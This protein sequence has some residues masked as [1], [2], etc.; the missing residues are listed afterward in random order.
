MAEKILQTR[1][2]QKV[3]TLENWS[4][5]T[6]KIKKGE[7]CF[8]TV[9]AS[10]GTGLEEPVV[11]VKIGT[12]EEKTFSELP[13]AFHAKAA[14]VLAAC[15]TEAGLTAFVN[16]VIANAGIATDEAMQKLAERVTT[17]EGE[18]DA[19]QAAL[20][21]EETGLKARMTAAEGAIDALEELVGDEA[22]ADQISAAIAELKIAEYAK[23]TEV[24]AVQT[25][26]DTYKTSNDKA[27]AD[28]KAAIETEAAAA[29]AAEKTLTDAVAAIKDGTT[30]D[31]FADVETALAGKDTKGSAEQALADA[32]AYADGLA[33]NYDAKGDAAQALVD[34]KAYADGLAG[35]YDEE[36]AADQALIDAKAYVDAQIDAW[37]GETDT[38]PE[39]IAAALASYTTTTDMNSAIATAKGEAVS[40]ANTLNSDMNARVEALEAIDHEHTFVESELNKIADGDVAKWNAAEQNAKDYAD[41]LDGAMDTRV[42]ALEDKFTGDDSVADQ[43]ADAVADE[44]ELREAADAELQK[45]IDAIEADYLKAADK[46]ALQNQIDALDTLVGDTAVATQISTAVKEEADRAKEIEGDLETR[47]K[48]VEDDHLVAADKAELVTAIADAKAEAIATVLGEGV[49]E[50]FDTLKEVAEWILSDTTGAAAL[51]ADVAAIKE[52]YLKA[53]DKTELEGKITAAQNAADKAQEEVDALELVVATKAAQADLEGVDGRVE[54]IETE[55]NTE[56]TGLKARMTTAEG[57]I[58]DLEELVGEDKV[59]DQINAAIEALKIGDYAKAADLVDAIARI[60]QNETDIEALQGRMDTAEADIETLETEVAKKANDAELAAIAKTGNVNDLIQTE[61]DV[62]IFDCGDAGVTA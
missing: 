56:A 57:A 34:A 53:A 39:Q 17:A 4:K 23:K 12:D 9:A 8:A 41:G 3:D 26:L 25:A 13:W 14:D 54:A 60:A 2:L 44:T 32:K 47:L 61:G 52:D 59:V 33:G 6:L 30:I 40:H 10:A 19:L 46:T 11:M 5:S 55:L 20:D 36:G 29:R 31:S 48:A 1:I 16:N 28:N 51:Q 58:D 15:K 24:E 43:I 42:K 62:L 22:V 18:I 21:T 45:A 35:N 49:D 7:L 27:V 38:V 37:V 50:D